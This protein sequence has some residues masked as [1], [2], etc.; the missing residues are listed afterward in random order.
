MT[1]EE[2]RVTAPSGTTGEVAGGPATGEDSSKA[3]IW[4]NRSYRLLLT[5]ST[6]E[7]VGGGIGAFAVPLV[8]YQITG[9]VV[10]A[11]LISFVG[12]LGSVLMSLPAGVVVDRVDRRRLIMT[13]TFVAALAWL[14]VVGAGLA[15]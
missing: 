5:G 1:T 9:S 10:Q 14:S 2:T 13:G 11:G 3:S 15:G 4:R 6:A 8:A 12:Q 7:V